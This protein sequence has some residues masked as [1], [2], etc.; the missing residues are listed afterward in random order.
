MKLSGK[1]IYTLEISILN[2]GLWCVFWIC[3]AKTNES[4]SYL[5]ERFAEVF[6]P[7]TILFFLVIVLIFSVFAWV[8]LCSID[9]LRKVWQDYYK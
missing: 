7:A 5:A 9:E 8:S 3:L 6:V 4:V 1:V 2:L